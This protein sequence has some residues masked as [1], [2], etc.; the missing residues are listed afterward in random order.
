MFH[1]QISDI[2][3]YEDNSTMISKLLQEMSQREFLQVEQKEGG[4]QLKLII[5]FKGGG[6]AMLKPMRFPRT[7]VFKLGL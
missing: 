1:S 7:Q 4:T 3:L 2:F 6:Q 5:S